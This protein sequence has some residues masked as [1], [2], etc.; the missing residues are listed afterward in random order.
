MGDDGWCDEC[1][2]E[3]NSFTHDTSCA[4]GILASEDALEKVKTLLAGV[5]AAV[6]E[7]ERR[8]AVMEARAES[9][10]K[11]VAELE[12][13]LREKL[14]W[15]EAEDRWYCIDCGARQGR[16]PEGR[17][18]HTAVCRLPELLDLPRRP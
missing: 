6:V 15:C 2:Y 4:L 3:T 12:S 10:L 18:W 9:A 7:G 5:D 8:E 13:V 1:G 16:D 17:G 11:R 14:F